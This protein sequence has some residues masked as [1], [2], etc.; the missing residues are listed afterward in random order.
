MSFPDIKRAL[1]VGLLFWLSAPT[2]AID[3]PATTDEILAA[4]EQ[5][6]ADGDFLRSRVLTNCRPH[7]TH[8]QVLPAQLEATARV[9]ALQREPHG[10]VEVDDPAVHERA[11]ATPCLVSAYTSK[12]F[13]DLLA[14][15][16]RF[17]AQ[18]GDRPKQMVRQAAL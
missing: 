16:G 11:V 1:F 9:G 2:F 15:L 17:E 18:L 4:Q 3:C 10:L 8:E 5:A 6:I 7:S 13:K 12:S 14:T